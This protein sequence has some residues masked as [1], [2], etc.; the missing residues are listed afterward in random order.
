MTEEQLWRFYLIL[1]AISNKN[2]TNYPFT[3]ESFYPHLEDFNPAELLFMKR[4]NLERLGKYGYL[5]F[6]APYISL[7]YTRGKITPKIIYFVHKIKTLAIAEISQ[8]V[9]DLLDLQCFVA[10]S[11]WQVKTFDQFY[12]N[13]AK[14]TSVI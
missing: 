12:Q 1:Q 3:A 9:E 4:N 8:K 2:V 6:Q 13:M 7:S 10:F 14:N 11:P 5:N